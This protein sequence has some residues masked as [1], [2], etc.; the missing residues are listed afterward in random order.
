MTWGSNVGKLYLNNDAYETQAYVTMGYLWDMYDNGLDNW[1]EFCLKV[2]IERES[3]M[4]LK[5]TS[6]I[7]SIIV[8]LFKITKV[9]ASL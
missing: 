5:F 3:S 7:L 6:D 9:L 1:L 8:R 4:L 2:E